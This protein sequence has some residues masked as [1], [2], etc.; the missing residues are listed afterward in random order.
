[1]VIRYRGEYATLPTW[2]GSFF[3]HA[4]VYNERMDI[5][6]KQTD[7]QLT[8]EVSNYI[9]DK[10]R[11]IEKLL[12]ADAELARCEIEIGRDAGGQRHGEHIWFAEIN[13]R[14][15]GGES[16]R[17]TNRESTINAA[18][19]M[20]K[21]EAVRQLR[22]GRQA[23]KRFLRKSGAAIKNLMRWGSE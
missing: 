5:R 21:D 12:G 3:F 1:M 6:I 17:V 4:S 22:K 2:A 16:V 20:A 13:I 18:I 10:M 23:H 8:P 11:A 19:D 15:P 9:D 14:Y 7:Y